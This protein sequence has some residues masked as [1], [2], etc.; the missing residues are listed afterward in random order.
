MVDLQRKNDGIGELTE[1]GKEKGHRFQ[2]V[3]PQ[4]EEVGK[5]M[6]VRVMLGV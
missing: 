5:W 3:T 4:P 6:T 2:L 1:S